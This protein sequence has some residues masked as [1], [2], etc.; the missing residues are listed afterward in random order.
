MERSLGFINGVLG[1]HQR[2]L[3]QR[4]DKARFAFYKNF[5]SC[6]IKSRL[7]RGDHEHR[8]GGCGYRL[9]EGSLTDSWDLSGRVTESG[10]ELNMGLEGKEGVKNLISTME[11]KVVAFEIT[12]E[13]NM[14]G[15]P[16]IKQ[17][18]QFVSW[19]PHWSQGTSTSCLKSHPRPQQRP[20]S[21]PTHTLQFLFLCRSVLSSQLPLPYV[22]TDAPHSSEP[23][24]GLKP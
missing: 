6:W 7:E 19:P 16:L 15:I 20:C 1:S 3:G 4:R 9:M 17:N 22:Q 21:W 12:E 10:K 18:F 11:W 14:G 8:Q 13:T 2:A 5:S 24:P 23:R